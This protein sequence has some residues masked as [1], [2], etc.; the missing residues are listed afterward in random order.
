MPAMLA[1]AGLV[2]WAE[3]GIRQTV[4]FSSVRYS[5][6]PGH[7]GALLAVG[8]GE[9]VEPAGGW[10]DGWVD[11]CAEG[12]PVAVDAERNAAHVTYKR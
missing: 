9:A 6:P 7:V 10:V 5:T 8:S 11:G 1:L 3:D 4:R 12:A 2:P